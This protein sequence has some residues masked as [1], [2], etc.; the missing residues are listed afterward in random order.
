MLIHVFLIIG[1]DGFGDGLSDG[2][3]LGGMAA[4]RDADTDVDG[5]EFVEADD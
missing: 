1:H 2:V 5:G 3:D 4:T